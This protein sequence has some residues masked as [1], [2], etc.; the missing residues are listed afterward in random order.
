MRYVNLSDHKIVRYWILNLSK[1]IFV[2]QLKNHQPDKS[3]I[4][5]NHLAA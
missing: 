3:P 1:R 2:K 4:C 5:R